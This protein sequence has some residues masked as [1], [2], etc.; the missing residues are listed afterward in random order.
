VIVDRF[1]LDGDAVGLEASGWSSLEGPLELN[2]SVRTP[3]PEVRIANLPPE[4]LDA[5]TDQEGWVRIPL[6][7]TG[8]RSNPRVSPDIAALMADARHE[9]ERSLASKAAEKLKGLLR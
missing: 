6:K 4:V 2:V 5:L 1:R 8:T 9:G 7:V 3:R